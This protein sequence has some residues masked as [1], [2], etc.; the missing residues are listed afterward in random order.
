MGGDVGVRV[1]GLKHSLLALLYVPLLNNVNHSHRKYDACD[2]LD[3]VCSR[4]AEITI[5]LGVLQCCVVRK[6]TTTIMVL[7]KDNSLKPNQILIINCLIDS[8]W[9]LFHSF[10][11]F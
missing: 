10:P 9:S 11:C 2:L 4:L 5:T 6:Q 1:R 7:Y 8:S 3:D